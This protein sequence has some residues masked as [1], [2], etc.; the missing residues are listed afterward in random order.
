[1]HPQAPKAYPSGNSPHLH[2][3][4]R[5]FLVLRAGGTSNWGPLW[6]TSTFHKNTG[7]KKAKRHLF[8][9][10]IAVIDRHSPMPI[11]IVYSSWDKSW[12]WLLSPKEFGSATVLCRR[13]RL[14]CMALAKLLPPAFLLRQERLMGSGSKQQHMTMFGKHYLVVVM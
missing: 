1:M 9:N 8:K 10:I 5:E 2:G 12:V 6:K 4:V 7:R 3:Q 13:A 14:F 11:F